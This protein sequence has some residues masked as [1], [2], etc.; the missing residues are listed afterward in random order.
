MSIFHFI[1]FTLHNET[2]WYLEEANE[3][4]TRDEELQH[5]AHEAGTSHVDD[6]EG[7]LSSLVHKV[8]PRSTVI[9]ETVEAMVVLVV[10]AMHAIQF[11]MDEINDHRVAI[12]PR[13]SKML[14]KC[15][16]FFVTSDSAMGTSILSIRKTG[17]TVFSF[18]LFF[19]VSRCFCFLLA[20]VRGNLRQ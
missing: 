1:N 13:Y 17:I 18:I 5:R 4:W 10:L 8:F 12:R 6:T 16:F 15:F 2:L 3:S 9:N 7:N 19:T 11:P 14:P 20:S